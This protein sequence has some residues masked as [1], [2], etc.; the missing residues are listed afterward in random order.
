MPLHYIHSANVL[1]TQ[2]C[3][4]DLSMLTH[5]DEVHLFQLLKVFHWMNVSNLFIHSSIESQLCTFQFFYKRC[6][7][8]VFVHVSWYTQIKNFSVI[9][10]KVDFLGFMDVSFQFYYVLQN[11]FRK[12]LYTFILPSA[13]YVVPI[14][15]SP[16]VKKNVYTY[17]IYI[18]YIYYAD[19]Y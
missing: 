16:S 5:L 7:N 17:A 8:N 13:V 1:F 14:F 4:W 2:P 11:S 10:L 6:C 12:H 19:I 15:L 9:S 3:F 18:W